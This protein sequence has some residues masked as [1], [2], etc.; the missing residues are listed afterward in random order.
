[1]HLSRLIVQIVQYDSLIVTKTYVAT[2]V[3][4]YKGTNMQ[5]KITSVSVPYHC[6]LLGIGILNLSQN[7]EFKAST[8]THWKLG[9]ETLIDQFSS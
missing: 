8:Q 9:L 5:K 2:I 6:I 4:H 1:M 3:R 7:D